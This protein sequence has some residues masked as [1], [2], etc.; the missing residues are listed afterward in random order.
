[1]SNRVLPQHLQRFSPCL[2]LPSNFSVAASQE[3]QHHENRQRDS[4]GPK[5][6]PAYLAFFIV[7]RNDPPF[8]EHNDPPSFSFGKHFYHGL[9]IFAPSNRF[10][11]IHFSYSKNVTSLKISP[12]LE[13]L[14]A[15]EKWHNISVACNTVNGY[16]SSFLSS[17]RVSLGCHTILGGNSGN[18]A[19]EG[20]GRA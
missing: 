17:W 2:T 11:I 5:Q 18:C 19:V 14:H 1:M 12:S 6:Y 16:T 8:F 4:Q 13:V 20:A 9:L 15:T 10:P 3:I 7:Q